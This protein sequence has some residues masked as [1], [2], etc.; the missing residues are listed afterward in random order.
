MVDD[1]IEL[2]GLRGFEKSYPH[3][4]SGGMCQIASLARA[5]KRYLRSTLHIQETEITRSL[6]VSEMKYYKSWI[7]QARK[8]TPNI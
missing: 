8:K 1:F 5:L 3:Q 4:L 6:S 2:V 7:L